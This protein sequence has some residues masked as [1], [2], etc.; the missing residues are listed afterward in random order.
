[1][2]IRVVLTGGGTAGH[3]NPNIAL[4]KALQARG[5]DLLYIGSKAGVEHQMITAKGIPYYAVRSGKLRRYFS[6]KNIIDP[7][8]V[9]IG[10][11]QAIYLLYRLKPAI[12]FS[13]GGFVALP[14]VIGAW[15]NRIPVI[16]HESDL[17]PGL[18]NRLSLP[19]V[20]FLCINFGSMS[21]PIKQK[22]RVTG[23]PIRDELLHGSAERGRAFC[24]IDE[25]KPCLLIMG[26]SQGSRVLNKAIRNILSSL[27]IKYYVIHLCGQGEIDSTLAHN[28]NYRQFEYVND[29]LAD[30]FAM[31]HLVIS[32]A[33][34]NA[35]CEILACKKPHILIPLSKRSS[36]GDQID[37]ARF[38]EKQGISLVIEEENLSSEILIQAIQTIEDNYNDIK[39]KI[40]ALNMSSATDIIADLILERARM[41]EKNT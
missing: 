13:K 10:I 22:I 11:I 25:K 1:M 16:A 40:E 9:F 19:F 2:T 12:V 24:K 21:T 29:E 37:N 32:R 41:R 8:N 3:V 28:P 5:C 26:G 35:L 27:T 23:T 33:G 17:T 4:I 15:I 31:T 14:V 20:D 39:A 36:R 38:F 6:W 34:A 30:L 18:A 7:L